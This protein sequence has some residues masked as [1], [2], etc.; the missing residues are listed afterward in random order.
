MGKALAVTAV[1]L[2]ITLLSSVLLSMCVQADAL[3]V[4]YE[5]FSATATVGL[6][7]GLTSAL[8]VWGKLI[9]IATMYLGRIGPISLVIALN[10]S[11]RNEN[12]VQDPTEEVSVG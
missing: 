3:D 5:T 4:L 7:R 8:D 1:S 9:V 11:K 12:A 2:I 6:S 10:V